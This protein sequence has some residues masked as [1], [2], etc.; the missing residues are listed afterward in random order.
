[1]CQA[2]GTFKKSNKINALHGVFATLTPMYT[3]IQPFIEKYSMFK[4]SA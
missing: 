4:M 2:G 1:M 3:Y